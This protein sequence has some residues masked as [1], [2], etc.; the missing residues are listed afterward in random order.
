MIEGVYSLIYFD[1]QHTQATNLADPNMQMMT[2]NRNVLGSDQ[3]RHQTWV[4][5]K[6][7]TCNCTKRKACVWRTVPE[8]LI[9][10]GLDLTTRAAFPSIRTQRP[11]PF[12]SRSTLSSESNL[13]DS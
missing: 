2:I 1:T 7:A 13:G 4:A 3:L 9:A 11:S 12:S 5:R 8:N 6:L 10:L